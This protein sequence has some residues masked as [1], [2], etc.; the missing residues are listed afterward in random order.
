[1]ADRVFKSTADHA[2]Q[3]IIAGFAAEVSA[4]Q[5]IVKQRR[6]L[7][8]ERSHLDP[9]TE[10]RRPDDVPY[11]WQDGSYVRRYPSDAQRIHVCNLHLV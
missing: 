11:A 10:G 8:R 3:D 5:G 1:M 7:K 6:A 9:E 4:G 2:E